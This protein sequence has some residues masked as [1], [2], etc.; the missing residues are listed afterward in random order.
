[1]ND[2]LCSMGAGT[3]NSDQFISFFLGKSN[4]AG[5]SSRFLAKTQNV[6]DTTT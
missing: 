5:I 3:G 1:M 2:F 6:L 4:F